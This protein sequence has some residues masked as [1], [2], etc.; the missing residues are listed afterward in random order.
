[1][2][3]FSNDQTV[4]WDFNCV[5]NITSSDKNQSCV[6]PPVGVADSYINNNPVQTYSN[7]AF[8]GYLTSGQVY[9]DTLCIESN[10]K[11]ILVYSA[12]YISEDNWLYNQAVV[13][14]LSYGI[15]GY[16]PN[17]PLWNQYIDPT[18]GI[19]TYSI[20]LNKTTAS[21]GNI[22]LG[23][24]F[25]NTNAAVSMVSDSQAL[26][27]LTTIGFG[28]VYQTNGVDTS[29]YF[30]NMTTAPV[31]FS[32]NY[33]GLGLP[34]ETWVDWAELMANL[35]NNDYLACQN[36]NGSSCVLS[37]PCSSYDWINSFSFQ[38]IFEGSTN[39]M[40]VP[41]STFSVSTTTSCSLFVNLLYP[42]QTQSSNIIMGY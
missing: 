12:N 19:A 6:Q 30:A 34:A 15:L 3:D 5:Q 40:R 31:Q 18:S 28:I 22:T 13:M 32:T 39:Y 41:L 36:Y 7:I 25:N 27:N 38:M 10:C 37:S 4:V 35:T 24:A 8:G 17:S 20:S 23:G 16:G 33:E 14:V 21:K 2:L 26:Y 29:S 1:M 42:N 11:E 9:I